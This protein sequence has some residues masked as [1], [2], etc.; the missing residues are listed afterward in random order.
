LSA[1]ENAV[2]RTVRCPACGEEAAIPTE[3]QSESTAPPG[4][5]IL[6]EIGRT[7]ESVVYAARQRALKRVVALKLGLG[8]ADTL[9]QRLRSEA[10]LNARAQ[11]HSGVVE[12]H[13]VG[14]HDA[15]PFLVMEYCSEG[16][17]EKKLAGTPMPANDAALLVSKL[18]PAVQAVHDAKVV[19]RDLKPANVLLMEDGT[20]KITGF[21]LAKALDGQTSTHFEAL[22]GT[23]SYLPPEQAAGKDVGPLADVYGLGAILYECLTGRPPFKGAT[24]T[25]TVTQ[26]MANEPARPSLLNPSVPAALEAICLKCLAK[27]PAQRY[28]NAKAL[29]DDLNRFL[30][31]ESV[32][33]RAASESWL[34]QNP[35][36]SALTVALGVT[37]G[38]GIAVAV[39]LGLS[40]SSQAARASRER[41][42]ANSLAQQ[43]E[44]VKQRA[45]AN[46]QLAKDNEANAKDN[47]EKA[48]Q[49]EKK[50]NQQQQQAAREREELEA[51]LVDSLMRPLSHSASRSDQGRRGAA[52][53][54]PVEAE[55]LQQLA[56]LHGDRLRLRFLETVLT[57][58]RGA[59]VA[60]R[61]GEWIVQSTV[62]LDNE[63]RRQAEALV[64]Q[65]QSAKMPELALASAKVGVEL[66]LNDPR[67]SKPAAE[68]LVAAM[69]KTTDAGALS[70]LAQTLAAVSERMEWADAIGH[71][72]KA[73]ETLVGAMTKTT[74]PAALGEL[75][76]G[77]QALGDRTPAR[78][79]SDQAA[80]AVPILAA[81]AGKA[82]TPAAAQALASAMSGV[83]ERLNSRDAEKAA[84]GVVTVAGESTEPHGLGA[85]A[86]GMSA[87]SK[88]LEVEAPARYAAKV[89][90][91]LVLALTKTT[92]QAALAAL[93]EGLKAIGAHLPAKEAAA[94]V[95]TVV[96]VIT[97]ATE[98]HVVSSLAQAVRALGEAR[99][100]KQK[101]DE[102]KAADLVVAAMTKNSDPATLRVLARGLEAVGGRLDG[103]DANKAAETLVATMKKTP[104]ADLVNALAGGLRAVGDRLEAK[105]AASAAETIVALM[106]ETKRASEADAFAQALKAVSGRLDAKDANKSAESLATAVA[107]A[108]NAGVM[109]P[110]A[111]ALK[112]VME[113]LDAKQAAAHATKAAD[114]IVAILKDKPDLDSLS[115]LEPAT[116]G[117]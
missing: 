31:G 32:A 43:V 98:P 116:P 111:L 26:V 1:D 110:L 9:A 35:V 61:R 103:K 38:L 66:N 42:R 91:P 85:V 17:L 51:A 19:H 87:V 18:A 92:D 95:E 36:V 83:C 27:E 11:G 70:S 48:K 93:V 16:S 30:A 99:D 114:A 23:P 40:A 86:L 55:S 3:S 97:K 77:L 104:D 62:G 20:P 2:A 117:R 74:D 102:S 89:A 72:T 53:L 94:F 69:N 84:I 56:G 81:A 45:D 88:R 34:R 68:A 50:A 44:E 73:G 115:A 113:R 65:A 46:A 75:A 28:R 79:S 67:W 39:L 109:E 90:D 105:D 15:R 33:P 101:A 22:V 107:N 52:P 24:A 58:P 108:A 7:S 6:F 25:D 112:A 76:L 12:L 41:D 78:L 80:R 64:L 47:E 8:R 106:V 29:G 37:L 59:A 5:A 21:G 57:D 49:N 60:G 14:E 96:E 13:E 63:R 100:D 10:E 82:K 54:G 71:T 4:Y